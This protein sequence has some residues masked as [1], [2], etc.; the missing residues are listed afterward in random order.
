M[1]RR[2]F[3]LI[4]MLLALVVVLPAQVAEKADT[5]IIS[6]IKDEGFTRSHIMETL[7][8]L[9]DV[10]GP[11][12]GW[13]PEYNQAA[14]WA[15]AKLAEW[16]LE[17]ARLEKFGPV[18]RGWTLKRLSANVIEPRAYPLIIYPKA[19]SPGTRGTVRAPVVYLD[20]KN[21]DELQ[22][23]KGKLKGA[24]VLM[25]PSRD[26]QAIWNAPAR[27]YSDSELLQMANAGPQERQAPPGMPD[28]A[29]MARFRETQAFNARKLQFIMDEGAVAQF[30]IASKGDGGTIF[31]SGATVPFPAN[32][33][34]SERFPAYSPKA[35]KARMLP[36]F[37]LTPE[38]YNR[39]VRQL[40]KGQNVRV[41]LNLEVEFTKADSTYNIIAELPGTDLKDEIVM[42]GGHF[43]SWHAGTGAT[44]N[45]T[46]SA[47]A[48]EAMRI[49]KALGLQPRRTIRI[50]LWGSEEQGLIG[51][52]AYV[53]KH[54]AEREVSGFAPV[55]P[56]KLKPGHEKF[57]VY[58][59]HDNGT[60]MVR[61]VYMQGNEAARPIFRAWLAPFA[62][63]GAST[64]TIQ[65]TGG[66]DH[67]AFDAVGLPGFQFIQDPI[68]YSP[69]THHSNMD[70]YDRVQP[71]DVKQAAIIMAAFAYN[72]AMRDEL[73]PRKPVQERPRPAGSN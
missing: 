14:E 27:R 8:W 51:S 23:Y 55:G 72:A 5:A 22:K 65:N 2:S 41:E 40:Q 67:L 34:Q 7:S 13:S 60:G 42:V 11:R 61:G 45:A 30:E 24:V 49:L 31:V 46:G 1:T 26:L 44:D 63:M 17:N 16:G 28:S 57:S 53:S 32:T 66:T 6:K 47:V 35:E 10:Y 52:R 19:W 4:V 71:E 68:E 50:G 3:C 59:N 58:F 54:F 62:E 20:V 18:G 9:T 15:R 38:H 29:A 36:Q 69:R 64:L 70:V 43:D 25:V 56:V 48:M 12:L 37:V 33:P 73:F 39:M 21:D